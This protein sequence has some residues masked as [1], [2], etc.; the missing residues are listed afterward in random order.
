MLTNVKL[1]FPM[2][3]KHPEL[4]YFDSGATSL[5]PKCVID[6]MV[7]FYENHTAN[8]GRGD[9]QTSVFVTR[10]FENAR[11]VIS[12][13]IGANLP[14]EVV[15]TG[16][17]TDSLNMACAGYFSKIVKEGDV[18]ISSFQEHASSVLPVFDLAKKTGATVK[19]MPL[20]K[21]RFD[22]V[23][24][25]E[26]LKE[27]NVKGVFVTHVS[28]VFGYVNPI[29]EITE[30]AHKYGAKVSIDGTQS[31]PHIK[32]DVKDLDVDF[33][34]FASHKMLGPSGLGVLYGKKELLS[35]VN[36][37]RLG[38]GANARFNKECDMILKPI[39]FSFEAGTPPIEQVL[40]LKVAVEYLQSLGFNEI[41]KHEKLLS[42][43]LIEG[44]KKFDNITVYNEDTDTGIVVFSFDGIFSQDVASY[45]SK[46]N[47]CV[48]GGNHCAKLTDNVIGTTDTLRISLYVYNTI[49][50][51]DR[52]L[53]VCKGVTLE[54]CVDIFL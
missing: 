24:F 53:E 37:L 4:T 54:N 52:F 27:G 25:E 43:R 16:G 34:S 33:F 30:L 38:G 9:Y 35:D 31:A 39:P 12:K 1:D 17:A 21:S 29:K 8:V 51:V 7:D 14:E 22:L 13:F 23:A 46:Q 45:L 10:E 18:L 44:L 28:N 48:R 40:A 32:V 19:Y 42:T 49:E 2:L 50:D 36:P 15:F 11:E 6:R 20:K 5:K 41:E 3:L 47:I 26:I